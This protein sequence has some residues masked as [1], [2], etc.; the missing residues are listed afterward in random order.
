MFSNPRCFTRHTDWRAAEKKLIESVQKCKMT[1][2]ITLLIKHGWDCNSWLKNQYS[3]KGMFIEGASISATCCVCLKDT[4]DAYAYTK[5]CWR[6]HRFCGHVS[7]DDGD[8]EMDSTLSMLL[9]VKL[10]LNS[11][12]KFRQKYNNVFWQGI[13]FCFFGGYWEHSY[14]W[15]WQGMRWFMQSVGSCLNMQSMTEKSFYQLGTS[16]GILNSWCEVTNHFMSKEFT[17]N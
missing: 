6:I 17:K 14:S 3:D 13:S 10:I 5:C 4:S 11:I 1:K 7:E 2:P 15:C 9:K 8:E 12:W 16:E